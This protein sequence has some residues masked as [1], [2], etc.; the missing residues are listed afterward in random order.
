M[1]NVSW[2]LEAE[3]WVRN[4]RLLPHARRFKHGRLKEAIEW[5]RIEPED[6]DQFA[7]LDLQNDMNAEADK[8]YRWA[9]GRKEKAWGRDPTS[10]FDTVNNLGCLCKKS[11]QACGGREDISAAGLDVL[12]SVALP[13]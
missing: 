1:A 13:I 6:L 7:Y 8:M 9:L 2:D 11:R 3:Y 4:W 12:G 10:T 5:S